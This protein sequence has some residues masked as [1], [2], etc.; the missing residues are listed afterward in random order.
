MSNY[1]YDESQLNGHGFSFSIKPDH[2]NNS[3]RLSHF[4]L[5]SQKINRS[6]FQEKKELKHKSKGFDLAPELTLDDLREK[7]K[8]DG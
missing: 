4:N 1:I 2:E 3:P 5:L 8:N 6:P 7:L